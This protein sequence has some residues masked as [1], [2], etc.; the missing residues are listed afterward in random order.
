MPV[1]P[2]LPWPPRDFAADFEAR[3]EHIE[4]TLSELRAT[5]RGY[6][7]GVE[8]ASRSEGERSTESRD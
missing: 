1:A 2:N 8:T 7:A 4:A 5:I 3:F 6:V